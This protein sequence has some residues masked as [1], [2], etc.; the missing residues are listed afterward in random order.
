MTFLTKLVVIFLGL[1]PPKQSVNNWFEI[2][3]RSMTNFFKVTDRRSLV[4]IFLVV[5]VY[6]SVCGGTCALVGVTGVVM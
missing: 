1:H 6:E 3:T 4:D 2:V 5:L